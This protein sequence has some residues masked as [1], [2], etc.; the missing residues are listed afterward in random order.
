MRCVIDLNNLSHSILSGSLK[1][2]ADRTY[3]GCSMFYL[4]VSTTPLRLIFAIPTL[5][6]PLSAR[7]GNCEDVNFNFQITS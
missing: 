7:Y 5:H 6:F 3:R 2:M 4:R 1:N